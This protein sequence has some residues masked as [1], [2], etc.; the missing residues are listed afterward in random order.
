M[1]ITDLNL[2]KLVFSF[3]ALFFI[4]F[5]LV[6]TT[7]AYA[8]PTDPNADGVAQVATPT[9][10]KYANSECQLKPG[11]DDQYHIVGSSPDQTCVKVDRTAL[12]FNIPSL[13]DIL[14]FAIRGVFVFGGLAALFMLLLGAFSWITSGG[15][16]EKVSAAQSKI[17]A[18]V[19]GVIM[20][21]VALAIVVTLEQVIF[22]G[23]ICLGLSCPIT[24][25]SLLK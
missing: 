13:T 22:S 9:I 25:P 1:K 23:K 2:S 11:T 4:A 17:T 20:I 21:A 14:S 24:I 19:I 10:G 15:D 8:V 16:K 5:S 7:A 6:F 12:G 18:A 3:V